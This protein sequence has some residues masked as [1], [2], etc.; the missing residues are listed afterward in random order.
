LCGLPR[1]TDS[2]SCWDTIDELKS[3]KHFKVAQQLLAQR[4]PDAKILGVFLTQC[5]A[6]PGCRVRSVIELAPM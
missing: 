3:G 6:D 5:L 2:I 4:F 1:V